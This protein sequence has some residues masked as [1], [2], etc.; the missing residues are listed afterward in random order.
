MRR[1]FNLAVVAVAFALVI[2]LGTTS[3]TMAA[4]DK[5][6]LDYNGHADLAGVDEARPS[7]ADRAERDRVIPPFA[8]RSYGPEGG[9]AD[10]MER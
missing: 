10:F 8:F 7:R 1:L 2:G 5:S 4:D 9:Y 6:S 3:S